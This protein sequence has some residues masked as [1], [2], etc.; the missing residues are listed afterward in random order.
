MKIG[1]DI[2]L[3]LRLWENN[4]ETQFIEEASVYHKRR[5]TFLQFFK[6]T[7]AFGKARPLLNR[8]YPKSAKIT[9]WFPTFFS[10]LLLSSI[11]LMVLGTSIF[12]LCF[13][14]YFIGIIID[15]FIKSKNIAVAIVSIITTLIQFTGYGL[16][17]IYGMLM[18]SRTGIV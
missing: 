13:A 15:S 17:F 8:K 14:I 10:L 6:Q 9:Y 18:S 3:T 12:L 2:D 11:I 4:Y 5:A 16:G 1:E 7:F